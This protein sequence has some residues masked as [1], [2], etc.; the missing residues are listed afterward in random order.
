VAE[1]A[2][3]LMVA[4]ARI[5]LKLGTVYV[6]EHH[7]SIPIPLMKLSKLSAKDSRL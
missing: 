4:V 7:L 3:R 5:C 6:L 2:P 1:S